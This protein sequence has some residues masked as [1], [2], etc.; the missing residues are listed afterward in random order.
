MERYGTLDRD[1]RIEIVFMKMEDNM[2]IDVNQYQFDKICNQMRKDFGGLK[3]GEEEKHEVMLFPMEGNLLKMHRANPSSNSRRLLEA[4]PLALF[5]I[6]SYLTGEEFNL[7]SFQS[8]DNERLVH[9]LL[10]AFDPFTNEEIK[11]VLEQKKIIDLTDRN[12]L[13]ALYKEPINCM[14]RIKESVDMWEKRMGM[15]GY[16]SF[17]EEYMGSSIPQEEELKYTIYLGGNYAGI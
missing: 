4:I 13:K 3:K 15:N 8:T 12:Q 17:I 16:F 9:A 11:V 2:E 1:N 5:Q 10:M 7:T 14:L 6:K